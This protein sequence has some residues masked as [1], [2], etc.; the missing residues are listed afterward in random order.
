MIAGMSQS[1]D[2]FV[3]TLRKNMETDATRPQ[4]IETIRDFGYRFRD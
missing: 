2:R 1:I 3:T 4:P